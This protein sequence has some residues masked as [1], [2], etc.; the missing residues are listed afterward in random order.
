M[1]TYTTSLDGITPDKLR[2]FFVGW[3]TPPSPETHLRLLRNSSHLVLAVDDETGSVVGFVTAVSDH[4][5]SA[6]ISLLEV[7]PQYRSRGVGA[8][9]VRRILEEVGDLYMIDFV[10]NPAMQPFY[11][12]LGMRPSTGMMRRNPKRQSGAE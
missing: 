10:C 7:L 8:E 4:V 11:T 2:G 9:L 3:T 6:S 5:L 1:I 12:R